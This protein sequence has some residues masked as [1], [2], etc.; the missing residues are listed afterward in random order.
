MEVILIKNF[1][2]GTNESLFR[3]LTDLLSTVLMIGHQLIST[4]LFLK[5]LV[6][7]DFDKVARTAIYHLQYYHM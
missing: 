7:S 2:T 4:V 5:I 6:A 3:Y 1:H